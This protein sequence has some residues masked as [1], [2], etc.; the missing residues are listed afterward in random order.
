M[1]AMLYMG[2]VY[3]FFHFTKIIIVIYFQRASIFSS[4]LM[5][6]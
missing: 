3:L 2:K 4:V 6:A 5:V 1:K